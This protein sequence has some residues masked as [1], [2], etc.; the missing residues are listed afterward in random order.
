MYTHKIL[1]ICDPKNPYAPKFSGTFELPVEYAGKKRRVLAYVP[2]DI[3]ESTAGILVLGENGQ[4]A[5]D[6]LEHSGWC[7]IADTEECKERLIVFFLEPENGAWNTIEAYGTPDGDVAYINAAALAAADRKLFCVHESKFYLV[8]CKEGGVLAN[9]AAAYDPAF[10]AGVA[11]VGGSAV[12]E[13]YLTDCGQA[14]ALNLDGFEDLEHRK[15]IHK[16]DIPMPAWIIDDPT[17]STGTGDAIL[18]YWRNACEAEEGRQLS[19]DQYEY[20]RVKET[21]YAP[22]Q[23]KEAY[24]VCHSSIPGASE[25]YAKRLQRRIWK[26]FLYRQRRWMSSPGGELR[27]TK[28]PVRDLVME[29]HYEEFDGWMREWYVYIP[30]SV[31]QNPEKKVPLV[32]AMHGYTCTGEIYAGNSGWYD[33]ADKHGFIV[34]FPTALHAKVDMPEQGL[35]PDWAPLNAWNVF[36]EDDRPDE[37][38]FFS[39]LLDK[40][41]A[42]YPVDE[43]RVFATG[44]SWGSLMTEML[45]LG[46]TERFAAVAPCSGAFFG[47][48]YEK[49]TS[50]PYAAE[51]GVQLPIWMFWGMNEEWLI[52]SEP[53]HENETGLTVELWLK[54]NGKADMIPADWAQRTNTVN[55]RFKDHYFDREGTAPVQFT[56]VDYMPHA[57]MPEMSFRIWEEFFSKFSRS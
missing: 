30:Q 55:G 24:R 49:M 3:R 41:I 26:D 8:G 11:S 36:L 7:E 12:S 2:H 42:E 21:P 14:Y 45:A 39:F 56:Q 17:V 10:F 19:P 16:Q 5:D 13:Q 15:D 23:E 35:M 48:A 34:V 28:D 38:K 20:Y 40:M 54:R 51:N 6:L 9:M 52:P 31:R 18:T 37:L 46:L 4:T 29:Y 47:G 53:T 57:T 27:V 25:Q 44:H 1:D 32:L 22:N 50:L 33:V 43:H